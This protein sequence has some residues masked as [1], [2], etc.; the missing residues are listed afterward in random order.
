MKR[1]GFTLIELLVVIAIIAVLASILFPVFNRARE[2]ARRA[3][4]AS[5]LKQLGL[6]IMQYSQDYDERLPVGSVAFTTGNPVSNGSIGAGWAGQNFPYVQSEQVYV[7]ASDSSD[8][9]L[10]AAGAKA[11]SYGYNL[12][13]A[14]ANSDAGGAYGAGAALSALTSSPKT[15]MLFEVTGSALNFKTD[16]DSVYY[17][18]SF[19][20]QGFDIWW[21][22]AG[23]T[24]LWGPAAFNTRWNYSTGPLSGRGNPNGR[25]PDARHFDGANYLL[26][27][28]HVKWFKG[29]K[30]SPGYAAS[31]STSAET[32]PRA[33]GA[34]YSGA[35]A[36]AITFSTK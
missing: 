14:N 31:T 18:S 11:A 34:E 33:E 16:P 25:F 13:L 6:G 26:A 7:C 29:A 27:D 12:V 2:N 24:S 32:D 3:S 36:H 28:G 5:N 22:Q 8:P 1:K 30:V 21:A 10:L 23:N 35:N 4:C 9:S 17:Q 20:G 19:V 15:V